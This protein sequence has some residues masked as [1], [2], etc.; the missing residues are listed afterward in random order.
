M[1]GGCDSVQSHL[2]PTL[3]FPICGWEVISQLPGLA[4]RCHA[5]LATMDPPPLWNHRPKQTLSS[6]RCFGGGVLSH[7]RSTA[8][9]WTAHRTGCCGGGGEQERT[10]SGRIHYL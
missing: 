2:T 5:F 9:R 8:L 3:L 10:G 7:P 6:T 1:R 4:A